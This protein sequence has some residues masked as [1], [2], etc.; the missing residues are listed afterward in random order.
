MRIVTYGCSFTRYIYPTYADILAQ[1]IPV[2][3]RAFPGSGNERIFYN[4]MHDY[5]SGILSKYN[6]VVVQWSAEHRFDYLNNND[7][8]IGN[9]P[10]TSPDNEHIWNRINKWYNFDYESIKTFNYAVCIKHL[11]EAVNP[12]VYYLS[13]TDIANT[14]K[15]QKI[16]LDFVN[17]NDMRSVYP[18][19]YEFDNVDWKKDNH[20]TVLE[21]LDI[22]NK[23]SSKFDLPI[24]DS[25]KQK[26]LDLDKIIRQNRVFKEYS[27]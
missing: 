2:D 20:P 7:T 9:G 3:N 16:N 1:E 17:I 27:L 6:L 19:G 15:Q 26:A 25:T 4:I 22:A 23:I 18:G 11:L 10:I 21:H 8:W 24:N 14:A 13:M 12:N 5:H